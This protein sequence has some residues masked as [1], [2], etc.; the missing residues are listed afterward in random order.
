MK[1]V[2]QIIEDLMQET[3]EISIR[4]KTLKKKVARY[5]SKLG[6]TPYLPLGFE[7]PRIKHR[8][9]TD[10]P[11]KLLAQLNFS[12]LPFL[13]G[14]PRK[15]ILQ[16]FIDPL[17]DHLYGLDSQRGYHVVYHPEVNTDPECQ[18]RPP[19]FRQRVE[20]DFVVSNERALTGV[21]EKCPIS[22][23]DYRFEKEL[24]RICGRYFP[25]I[26]N[27]LE[28]LQKRDWNKIY[29]SFYKE[30]HRI[31]GYPLFAKEDPRGRPFEQLNFLLLQVDSDDQVLWGNSGVANFFISSDDLEKANFNN[32]LYNWDSL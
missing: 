29:K 26:K 7:Y 32:I 28:A 31:G 10:M 27:P 18:Q 3:T 13:P 24:S 8:D 15:G 17:D 25:S 22:M 23:T 11:M 5:N 9:E 2:N 1:M 12:E 14:L 30:G 20:D 6:G 16:F 4:L 21:L 19:A